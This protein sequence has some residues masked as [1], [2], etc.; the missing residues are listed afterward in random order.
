LANNTFAF[1]IQNCHINGASLF[2]FLIY[3][4]IARNLFYKTYNLSGTWNIGVVLF[5]IRILI[6]FL[7]YTLPFGNIRLW[8]ATVITNLLRVIPFVGEE[9]V[10][11]LWGRFFVSSRT[12]K[13][14]FTLH[15]LLPLVLFVVV[16]L[17][18]LQLH[19]TGRTSQTIICHRDDHL[20]FYLF[21][22]KDIFNLFVIFVMIYLSLIFPY[23]FT[24]PDSYI[25]ANL[26]SSPKHII[27]E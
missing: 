9:I 6:A 8:A 1:L 18:L 13:L 12:I 27:P 4:H 19:K 22:V 24:E 25:P 21:G 11:W 26:L 3:V 17:H 7:G 23:Q 16:I 5:I 10:L 2:F 14:F 20:P 15:F